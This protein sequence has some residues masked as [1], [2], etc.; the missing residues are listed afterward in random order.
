MTLNYT[1]NIEAEEY[2]DDWDEDKGFHKVLFKSGKALQSRELN[3]LQSII[4]GEIKRLGTNLFKEGASLESA[5]LTVNNRYRYIKLNTDPTDPV[6]P[7]VALPSNVSN[8]K[9]KV[10]VGQVSGVH[11]KVIELV[12]AENGDPAT[13]YVQYLNT[14]NATTGTVPASANPGEELL[15]KDGNLALV[16]QTTNTTLDPA[17]GYG[18]RISAGPGTFFA[19]GHFVHAPKQSLILAKYF[20]NPTATVGFKLTQSI[21]TADD[22]ETLYDNQGDNPN[23]TAPGADRYTINLTLT[24]KNKI[25]AGETFIYYAKIEN[26]ILRESVTGYDQYNKIND[27]LAARTSEESGDYTVK[28]FKITWE[29]H[30]SDD[31]KLRLNISDGLAYVDGYRINKQSSTKLDIP[32]STSTYTLQN[33]AIGGT[34]GNYVLVNDNFYGISNVNLFGEEN[35]IPLAI[36]NLDTNPAFGADTIGYCRIRALEPGA[37]GSGT[38]RAYIFDIQMNPGYN[39]T[40][41]AKSIGQPIALCACDKQYMILVRNAGIVKIFNTNDNDLFFPIPG[42]RPAGVSD[43][44][45][46]YSKRYTA[47]ATVA[48]GIASIT[49][50]AAPGEVFQDET[51]WIIADAAGVITGHSPTFTGTG[52]VRTISN[53]NT[54][55]AKGDS[56]GDMWEVLATSYKAN[57]DVASKTLVD[58]D[59]NVSFNPSTGVVT[60]PYTDVTKIREIRTLSSSGTV[61]TNKFTL[62]NGQRDNAYERS[63]LSLLPGRTINGGFGNTPF[64]LHVKLTYFKHGSGDF[65]APNSYSGISYSAIPKY[66]LKNGDLIDL[67]NYLDFRSSKGATGNFSTQGAQVFNVPKQGSTITAD[68]SYYQGRWDKLTLSK[69]GTFDYIKGIEDQFPKFP[70]TPEESMLTHKIVLNPG[71]FGPR[72]LTYN[73]LDN[74]RYTMRDI[75]KIDRK[76]DH[77]AEVTSLTLLEM[78][79]ANIDVLDSDNRNRTKTGFMADNFE[80]HFYSDIY[81]PAYSAA[82]DPRNKKLTSKQVTNQ[83]GLYYDSNASTNTIMMGDNIYTQYYET[84]LLVQDVASSTVNVNPYLNLVYN[85]SMSLSPSSDT[86]WEEDWIAEKIHPGGTLLQAVYKDNDGNYQPV[87]EQN[88][89]A[90]IPPQQEPV[91]QHLRDVDEWNWGGVDVD[92]LKV[93]DQYQNPDQVIS[94]RNWKKKVGYFWN[95]KTTT[96]TDQTIETVV[97]RVVASETVR[98]VIGNRVIDTALIPFI[99]SARVSFE[100]TG[101]MPNTQVFPYFDKV[102]VADWVRQEASIPYN[103]NKQTEYTNL[104][105]NATQYPLGGGPTK[106]YTDGKGTVRGS[107]FIPSTPTLR[108]R[109][110]ENLEFC[111]LDITEY[112]KPYASCIAAATYT[113]TGWLETKQEDV[114]STRILAVTAERSTREQTINV[115]SR[116]GG[117]GIDFLGGVSSV[118]GGIAN[119]IGEVLQGDLIGGVNSVLDGVSDAVGHTLGG[120]VDMVEQA[121]DWVRDICLFDPIAQSFFVDKENGVYITKVGLFFKTRDTSDA[122]L[123]LSIEIRPM[124]GGQPH[125][126]AHVPGSRVTIPASDVVV[127]NDATLETQIS[128]KEPVYL[129]PFTEY[130]IVVISNSDKYECW[131]STMGEFKVGSTTEKVNTQPYLGSFFKSQNARTWDADQMTDMKFTLYKAEFKV[132]QTTKA[133]F[134]NVPVPRKKLSYDPIELFFRDSS[135][136]TDIKI[137]QSNHG[138]LVGDTINLSGILTG[139]STLDSNLNNNTHTI[140]EVDNSGFVIQDLSLTA[141]SPYFNQITGGENVIVDQSYQY[142]VITPSITT[143]EPPQTQIKYSVKTAGGKSYADGTTN[144]A[145]LVDVLSSTPVVVGANTKNT[146]PTLKRISPPNVLT[147]SLELEAEFLS[148]NVFV[149]PMIDIQRVAATLS[150]NIIDNP[151]NIA[152]TTQNVPIEWSHALD[153]DTVNQ[154]MGTVNQTNNYDPLFGEVKNVGPAA[155]KHV[156]K[157][158][159]LIEAAVGLKIIMGANVPP[160]TFI[161]MYY[162]IVK[163]ENLADVD[164]KKIDP[165]SPIIKESDPARYREVRYL[166]GKTDGTSDDFTTFQLKIVMRS[167]DQTKVPQINDLRVIALG[168]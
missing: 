102:S 122:A 60:L 14:L 132:N 72:D 36:S 98:E 120:A 18:Y 12:E 131:V 128:F 78:D 158:V 11:V 162:K 67:K 152:S 29:D 17:T 157:A 104:Y 89:P 31:T 23:Y 44:S 39:F 111:L 164:W 6:T 103:Q 59:I 1:N 38:Y 24:N 154:I 34:F 96:G 92:D 4:Q 62:D 45:I 161:D 41:D 74:K 81:H 46:T 119:G 168:D 15:E 166:V 115:K 130:S 165:E 116:G 32:R 93:G 108:F 35:N 133:V 112:N 144:T 145:G 66:R 75:S 91:W 143:I 97:N 151:S 142:H 68:I 48:G 141:P 110:T 21:T 65:F 137:N 42:Y 61:V 118:A 134:K 106:L 160:N 70:K 25:Q 20:S 26:G 47:T 28:P 153:S 125:S 55:K 167:P 33:Q 105:R 53:L 86:W 90:D 71:T 149:T 56:D 58:A 37:P 95:Q 16:V 79:T 64:N 114:L 7:G 5:A 8:F 84:P 63:K 30:P 69:M 123:P 76:I 2:R 19:A 50:N 129:K 80:N 121:W 22:D 107:F 127:S 94:E 83:I 146:L 10:F 147:T 49:L 73:M 138:L 156:T 88:R 3:Q 27:I 135:Q 100:A 99:R 87:V 54:S 51:S 163:S 155:C 57:A 126:T 113:A 13:I 148:N 77:L 85:G 140:T 52:A 139:N 43:V 136:H 124:E 109:T 117:G 9:D 150:T 159:D 101:L 40:T 82:I